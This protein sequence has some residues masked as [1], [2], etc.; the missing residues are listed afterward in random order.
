MVVSQSVLRGKRK[1]LLM[2]LAKKVGWSNGVL[3][4]KIVL[5]KSTFVLHNYQHSITCNFD[6]NNCY[7]LTCMSLHNH[8]NTGYHIRIPTY[9]Y[10]NNIQ[11]KSLP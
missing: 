5:T 9:M 3:L 8:K 10:T 7:N 2:F 4:F 1:R 11:F 6:A